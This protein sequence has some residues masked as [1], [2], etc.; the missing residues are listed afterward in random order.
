MAKK[1]VRKKVIEN[2]KA[3][4]GY[5][6]TDEL[7]VGMMLTG[8]E[9]K[10]VRAGQMQLTGSYGRV[11]QGPKRPELWLVGAN[12]PVKD[13]EKQRSI[14]LLA[15]RSEIDRL[16]GLVQQKGFTLVPKK[17]YFKNNRAKLLLN[18]SKGLKIHEKRDKI[19]ER[20]I[21]RDIAR[22]LRMK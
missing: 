19:R 4:F 18:V 22:S 1:K 10:S 3:N 6:A 7:E 12:I 9:V 21:D 5:Q 13:G 11:L 20:D 8:P 14:K 17:V 2:R 15:H 16:I